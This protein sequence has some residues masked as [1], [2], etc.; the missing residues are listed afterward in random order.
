MP[1]VPKVAVGRLVVRAEDDAEDSLR[2]TLKVTR[3][4]S[5]RERASDAGVWQASLHL[6]FV[7][8]LVP[9]WFNGAALAFSRSAVGSGDP[10]ARAV[11]IAF[12]ALGTIAIY[13][14]IRASY[15][16][17]LAPRLG[18]GHHRTVLRRLPIA[19]GFLAV[20]FLHRFIYNGAALSSDVFAYI[21][22]M[23]PAALLCECSW[24]LQAIAKGRH[25]TAIASKGALAWILAAALLPVAGFVPMLWWVPVVLAAAGSACT[26]PAAIR[27]WRHYEGEVVTA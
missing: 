14:G 3:K 4:K 27:I 1:N 13:F 23:A 16:L 18:R 9:A 20:L 7:V 10:A 17:S 12:I 11:Q 24:A 6:A 19:A 26:A 22:A 2:P 25:G 21:G 8:C 5:R 15:T